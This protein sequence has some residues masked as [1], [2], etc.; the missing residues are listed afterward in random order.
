[1]KCT[2]ETPGLRYVSRAFQPPHYAREVRVLFP[3][4]RKMISGDP[5]H[6]DKIAASPSFAVPDLVSTP[7]KN[8]TL[9]R[10]YTF[11]M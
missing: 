7:S 4:N 2:I 6:S 3:M 8:A 10:L 11:V 1:M 9:Y 5:A